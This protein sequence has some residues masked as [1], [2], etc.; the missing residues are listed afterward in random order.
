MPRAERGPGRVVDQDEHQAWLAKIKKDQFAGWRALLN[1]EKVPIFDGEPYTGYYRWRRRDKT[2]APVAVWYEEG[3]LAC[4][5]DGRMIAQDEAQQRWT[6]F[7]KHPISYEWYLLVTEQG[8]DWPDGDPAVTQDAIGEEP[9]PAADG[10]NNPPSD[11]AILLQ[12]QLEA[13]AESVPKYEKIESEEQ[14]AAGQSVRSRLLELKGKANGIREGLKR[15]HLDA[16]RKIDE[17]W[18]PIVKMGDVEAEKIRVAQE[19]FRTWQRA[20]ERKK[21]EAENERIAAEHKK[22]QEEEAARI[23]ASPEVG[24]EPNDPAPPLQPAPPPQAPPLQPSIPTA[25]KGAY[26]RAAGTK[27]KM[28]VT[29]ITDADALFAFLRGAVVENADGT[30][31]WPKLHPELR[32]FMMSLA[33]RA[34]AANLE[35]P[36]VLIEEKAKV[37]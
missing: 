4:L 34:L 13:A 33:Q 19:N 2:F 32:E 30:K 23:A 17:K 22:A 7:A 6:F 10:S 16:N 18:M 5:I 35:P 20:E 11:P 29:A 8:K 31:V 12:E 24:N 25:V 27:F 14:F 26:G 28:T 21:I 36:G 9:K 15:E 3:V 37:T 1:K